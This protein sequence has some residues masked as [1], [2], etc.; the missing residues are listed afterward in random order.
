MHMKVLCIFQPVLYMYAYFHLFYVEMPAL[1]KVYQT[2][3]SKTAT[4]FSH[5]TDDEVKIYLIIRTHAN[6]QQTET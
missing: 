6:W 4:H 1:S 2:I 3:S 5:I